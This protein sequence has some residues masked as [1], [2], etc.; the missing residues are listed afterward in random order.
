VSIQQCIEEAF[1]TL[2]QQPIPIVGAG[3]TDAGVH[4]R[5]M[6]AHFDLENPLEDRELMVKK[7][8]NLLPEDIAVERIVHVRQ[9]AHARFSAL[10]R[11]YQYYITDIKNPF[12][13]EW[14]CRMSLKEMDFSLMNEACK[15]LCEYAD[16]TSFSKLH[17]DVKTHNCRIA[18]AQ[19]EQKDGMWVFTIQ[20]NR[21]L[22]NMVRAIVG[23]LFEV[24][25]GKCSLADFRQVIEAKDRCRAGTSAPAKGLSLVEITY[26]VELF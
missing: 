22:R 19:W 5:Q 7:L 8:N 1:N 14:V 12:T 20:A 26:P 2:Q 9:G 15:I 10:S 21:F 17:S 18:F 16:F 13:H 24:G 11:T 6:I 4:A 25:R 3:R 23:T